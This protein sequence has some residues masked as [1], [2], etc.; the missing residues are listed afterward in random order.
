MVGAGDLRAN[1]NSESQIPVSSPRANAPLRSRPLR[2]L[3]RLCEVKITTL[4]GQTSR[5]SDWR[6]APQGALARAEET[7]AM[8]REGRKSSGVPRAPTVECYS[9][10]RSPRQSPNTPVCR[11]I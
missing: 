3:Q 8:S 4:L 6:W 10:R 9:A 5:G 7:G 1:D 2:L 11:L